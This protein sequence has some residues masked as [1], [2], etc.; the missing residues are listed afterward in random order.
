MKWTDNGQKPKFRIG[1]KVY[2]VTQISLDDIF[3][4]FAE[5]VGYYDVG[6]K[7]K[8][9]KIFQ[10]DSISREKVGEITQFYHS[11]VDDGDD[12]YRKY[13]DLWSVS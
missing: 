3:I 10:Q 5:I 9:L 8:I 11:W 4:G 7:V 13:I 2:I 6:Y 1:A 12:Y